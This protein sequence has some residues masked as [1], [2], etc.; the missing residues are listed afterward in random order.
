[1]GEAVGESSRE[2]REELICREGENR[3]DWVGFLA[4][5]LPRALQAAGITWAF[6]CYAPCGR[7]KT[8]YECAKQNGESVETKF[9]R[10]R[11]IAPDCFRAKGSID[12]DGERWGWDPWLG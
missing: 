10:G 8:H 12:T 6:S 11:R 2:F 3:K 7:L 4:F 1:M 9:L 5:L